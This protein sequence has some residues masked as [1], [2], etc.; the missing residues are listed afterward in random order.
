MT[1]KEKEAMQQVAEL[2]EYYSMEEVIGFLEKRKSDI[3]NNN[4]EE[5]DLIVP[6]D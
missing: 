1:D 5:N 4:K 2:L 3:V 6:L